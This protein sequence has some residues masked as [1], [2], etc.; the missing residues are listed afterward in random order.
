MFDINSLGEGFH[1]IKYS[2]MDEEFL[3]GFIPRVFKKIA[4]IKDPLGKPRTGCIVLEC[5]DKIL[6]EQLGPELVI[7]FS[8][9]EID[10]TSLAITAMIKSAPDYY[11]KETEN[12][13]RLEGIKTGFKTQI[14]DVV[15]K[16]LKKDE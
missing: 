9:E 13:K 16:N 6:S 7:V 12:K 5:K 15:A 1:F 14:E 10:H 11:H 8:T 3:V 4:S 2:N